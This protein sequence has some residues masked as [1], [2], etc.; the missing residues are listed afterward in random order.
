MGR[1][2]ATEKGIPAPKLPFPMWDKY[3]FRCNSK[4]GDSYTQ[5]WAGLES[6][7]LPVSIRSLREQIRIIQQFFEDSLWSFLLMKTYFQP[8]FTPEMPNQLQS[9]DASGSVPTQGLLCLKCSL[10]MLKLSYFSL[11]PWCSELSQF[12]KL[13]DDDLS[14]KINY[15]NLT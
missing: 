8:I 6:I 3:I 7:M 11:L 10:L 1:C 13:S 15:L 12:N 4:A 14:D 2:Q 5:A 9:T